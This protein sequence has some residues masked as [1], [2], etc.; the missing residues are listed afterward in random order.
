M[1]ENLN[2]FS[3]F[4]KCMPRKF[5]AKGAEHKPSESGKTLYVYNCILGS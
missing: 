4:L 5:S 3:L 1:N 2:D